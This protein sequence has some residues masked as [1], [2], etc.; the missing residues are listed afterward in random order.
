MEITNKRHNPL[1]FYIRV[2]MY[3]FV[4][5]LSRI[6][7][8]V[9][10]AALFIFEEGSKLRWLALLCPLLLFFV[11]MPLRY[12]FAEALV[13]KRGSRYFSYD[14]AFSFSSY[15]AKLCEG[16]LHILSVLKWALPFVPIVW[17]AKK[18]Y[19]E[20]F[21]TEILQ[22]LTDLGAKAKEIW[23]SVA[24][25]F[26]KLFGQAPLAAPAGG[27]M[28]GIYV[29][30][31]VIGLALLIFLIGVMRNSATRYIW[32]VAKRDHISLKIKINKR[33]CI[34]SV[35]ALFVAIILGILSVSFP[36]LSVLNFLKWIA[37]TAVWYA[38]WYGLY[39]PEVRR[40][41]RGRR[42]T[43]LLVAL[44]N[45]VL[46]LPFFAIVYLCFKP[47]ITE[48]SGS[49]LNLMMGQKVDIAVDMKNILIVVGAFFGVYMTLLPARRILTAFFASRKLRHTVRNAEPEEA[50]PAA[51]AA[52][53][54]AP[55]ESQPVMQQ[56]V[57]QQP[58]APAIPIEG[59]VAVPQM[60]DGQMQ[61]VYMPADNAMPP[62]TVPAW[63]QAE[64][65]GT[66][67]PDAPVIPASFLNNEQNGS[68]V[69]F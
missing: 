60:V 42:F 3:M 18:C 30:L 57:M 8:F 28:E 53:E 1:T 27:I 34:F 47:M 45:L 59:M 26:L 36:R 14:K 38:P 16:M 39:R 66:A 61:Y 64:N 12:S 37:D 51:D 41:L 56:P 65:D 67:I 52:V 2:F 44:M 23:D 15:G 25:F 43:Q 32:A 21:F 9:P 55:A 69:N 62:A 5:L 7:C 17:Y 35:I 29:V 19:D 33:G 48:L 54:E 4:A 13:Q 31:G 49:L 6:I 10:L 22:S 46:L 68:D 50:F 58:M 11:V 24:N 20:M 40:R 63:A